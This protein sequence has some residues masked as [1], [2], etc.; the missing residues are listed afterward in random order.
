[1]TAPAREQQLGIVSCNKNNRSVSCRLTWRNRNP[2][3]NAGVGVQQALQFKLDLQQSVR[4]AVCYSGI[5]VGSGSAALQVL[6]LLKVTLLL[7]VDER[8]LSRCRR[9]HSQLRGLR[10]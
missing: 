1:M 5:V 9:V 8:L 3:Q 2:E 4:S 10:D 7:L 6:L